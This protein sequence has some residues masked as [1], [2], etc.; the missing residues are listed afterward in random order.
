LDI[1]QSN[2]YAHYGDPFPAPEDDANA[3]GST[4]LLKPPPVH[5]AIAHAT[6]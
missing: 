2:D 6:S 1:A 4:N 5:R 3:R